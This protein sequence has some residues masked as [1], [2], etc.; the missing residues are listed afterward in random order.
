MN[1]D[2][3]ALNIRRQANHTVDGRREAAAPPSNARLPEKYWIVEYN[4]PPGFVRHSHNDEYFWARDFRVGYPNSFVKFSIRVHPEVDKNI[5]HISVV[6]VERGSNVLH[7][8]K[9]HMISKTSDWRQR[10]AQ[11]LGPILVKA[12]NKCRREPQSPTP[13]SPEYSLLSDAVLPGFR[14]QEPTESAS[15]HWVLHPNRSS[16][17]T[18]KV[19]PN[20]PQKTIS[21]KVFYERAGESLK[22]ADSETPATTNIEISKWSHEVSMTGGEVRWKTTLA[23]RLGEASVQAKK[24]PKCPTCKK[25]AVLRNAKYGQFFGCSSFPRCRGSLSI[26]DFQTELPQVFFDQ[27]GQQTNLRARAA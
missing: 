24:Q 16:N 12:N 1:I 10:L 5:I 9:I 18:V 25:P 22:E 27:P 14:Y 26:G 6:D 7:R 20:L 2:D 3:D 17:L 19:Y 4:L 23:E 15:A 13:L 21:I 11:R 8:S